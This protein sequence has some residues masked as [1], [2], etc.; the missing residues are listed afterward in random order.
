MHY[1]VRELNGLKVLFAPMEEG[2]SV[3]VQVLV[4]A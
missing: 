2:N 4:K 1:E 3:T